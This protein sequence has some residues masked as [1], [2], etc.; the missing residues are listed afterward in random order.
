LDAKGRIQEQEVLLT[1]RNPIAATFSRNRAEGWKEKRDEE[2]PLV[3]EAR[4]G[5][6]VV[7]LL[8]WPVT[9]PLTWTTSAETFLLFPA[10]IRLQ[11]AREKGATLSGRIIC[12]AIQPYTFILKRIAS[13]TGLYLS[14][15]VPALK[16]RDEKRRKRM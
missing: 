5:F 11:A 6:V 15:Y 2:T 16:K 7:F 4:V 14:R 10:T 1:R 12:P 13:R 8:A 3:L 9:L